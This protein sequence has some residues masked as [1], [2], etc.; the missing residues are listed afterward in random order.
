MSQYVSAA[1]EVRI[2]TLGGEND[3]NRD[4]NFEHP[5]IPSAVAPIAMQSSTDSSTKI[6]VILYSLSLAGFSR[7][8]GSEAPGNGGILTHVG[9]VSLLAHAPPHT[10][11]ICIITTSA[12]LFL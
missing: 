1:L 8:N 7:P 11:A 9:P 6:F 2:D 3:E 12:L 4:F 10:P 5:H